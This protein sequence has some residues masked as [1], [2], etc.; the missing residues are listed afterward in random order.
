M[1]VHTNIVGIKVQY[2]SAERP[3][4]IVFNNLRRNKT[5]FSVVIN[6]I[7][8]RQPVSGAGHLAPP[9][10]VALLKMH[11]H[12]SVHREGTNTKIERTGT[13]QRRGAHGPC[14]AFSNPQ[15]HTL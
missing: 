9:R 15:K 12:Y 14:V 11:I 3:K 4:G 5:Q 10:P 6:R 2:A 1:H 8:K 7:I 13:Q